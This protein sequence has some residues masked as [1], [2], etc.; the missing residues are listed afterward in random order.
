MH[1][2]REAVAGIRRAP[3]LTV[4]SASMVALA[5]VVV[6]LFTLVSYNLH[7]ALAGLEDRVEVV[8]FVRDDVAPR[9]VQAARSAL[10]G[11]EAVGDVRFVTKEEALRSA[12]EDLPEFMEIFSG[13]EGNPLPASLE[14]SL[15]PGFRD[16]GS[17]ETVAEAAAL[18]PFVEDVAFGGEWVDRIF[19]L[20]RIGALATL[21]L[22]VAFAS[23]AA[24][25]IATAIRIAIF[26]RREEIQIMRLVGA[27][28]G[29]IR[30]PFLLEGF[31]MGLVGGILAFGLTY[32]AYL[33][34][35]RS[36][37]PLEWL[38]V[39]WVGLGILSGGIFG[40]VAGA[41]AVRRHLREI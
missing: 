41:F 25:I 35:N 30:R 3:L 16:P 7:Q 19:L 5:L 26:A 14:I 36:L 12:Q 29:F 10:L 6:G 33:T 4:L 34:G 22:G 21:V 18:L 8:A 17:V 24:L 20:R 13:L 40:V 11:L 31:L 2:L 1:A 39:E 37:L 27:R 15:R 23:V 9:E 32:A 28:N 38:P